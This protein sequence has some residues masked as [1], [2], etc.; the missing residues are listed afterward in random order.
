MKCI[1]A[2]ASGL[3]GQEL[4]SELL[5]DPKTISITALVRSDLP[6]KGPKIKTIITSFEQIE[7]FS[8]EA[9]DVGLCTLGTTIK[10]AGSEENFFHVDHD[11]VIHFAKACQNA[12]VKTFIIVS[13]LGADANSKIFYNKVKGQTEEDLK[14]LNFESLVIL[15]PSLLMGDRKESRPMEK[16]AQV[17]GHALSPLMVGPLAKVRPILARTIAQKMK[18]IALEKPIHG[19]HILLNHEI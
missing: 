1:I 3:V 17:L 11:L 14:K 9:A 2:G 16:L 12:G 8:I 5:N 10:K 6:I 4:L 13:A 19:T 18:A 15:R 7:N